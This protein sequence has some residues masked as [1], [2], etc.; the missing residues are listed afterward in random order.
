[1]AAG[2][3]AGGIVFGN[4][5]LPVI[6]EPRGPRLLIQ[7]VLGVPDIGLGIGCGRVTAAFPAMR[8]TI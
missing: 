3:R 5:L 8:A 4:D 6:D 7:A 1:M 2:D